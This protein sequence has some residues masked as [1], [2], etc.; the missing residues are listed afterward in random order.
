MLKERF[1]LSHFRVKDLYL[2]QDPSD[3]PPGGVF[4]P[5]GTG[6]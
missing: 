3:T 2:F 6:L 1:L 5:E 4:S